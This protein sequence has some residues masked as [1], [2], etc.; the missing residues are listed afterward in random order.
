[1][2]IF[3]I[4]SNGNGSIKEPSISAFLGYLL[5]PNREHG[6]KDYL[7]REIIRPFVSNTE[8]WKGFQINENVVNLTN[9]SS[10]RVEVILEKKVKDNNKKDRFIDIV[11][12]FFNK[13]NL[14][15]PL[16][17]VCIENKINSG[18]VSSNQLKNQFE[19]IKKDYPNIPLGF[20]YLTPNSPKASSEY[21]EFS[22]KYQN[23]DSYSLYWKDDSKNDDVNKDVFSIL[24]NILEL[25]SKGYIEPIF[26]YS[27]Y[28]IKSF[29]NFINTGFRSYVEE[30]ELSNKKIKFKRIFREYIKDVHSNLEDDKK[31]TVKDIKLK[32]EKLI[33][34]ENEDI[35]SINQGTLSAQLIMHIINNPT[36]LHYNVNSTNHGECDL[37]YYVDDSKEYISKFNS[38]VDIEPIFKK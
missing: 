35:E 30:K 32:I 34:D 1:M 37:F 19:G 15:V 13:D 9:D 22:K 25:E 17:I 33:K 7:L 8:V 38:N 5:D 4:L 21:E 18:S 20:I 31:Y 6:L 16:G 24:V 29:M 36:R 14:N 26:D 27:K 2:N 28:T 23:V 10:F 3:K 11:I 12:K